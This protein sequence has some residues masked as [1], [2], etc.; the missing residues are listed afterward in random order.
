MALARTPEN[1]L[2]V[3]CLDASHAKAA[4]LVQLNKID[5]NDADGLAQIIRSGWYKEVAVKEPR[6]PSRAG[7]AFLP[8]PDGQHAPRSRNK[9]TWA[10]EDI[11]QDCRETQRKEI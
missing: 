2:P 3:V 11:W 1:G 9:D 8:C 10:F 5:D 7:L 6:Q 4:L